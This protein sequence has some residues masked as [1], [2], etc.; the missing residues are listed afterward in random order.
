MAAER[1]LDA[2]AALFGE[3]GFAAVSVRDVALRAGVKKA[4]VFY[5][6]GSKAELFERVLDRYYEAHA[7]ALEA[8]ARGP[9]DAHE[10]LHR[11]LDGYLDFM[12]D[13]ERWVRLVQSELGAGSAH[14]PRIARGLE[15]LYERV[16]AVL[17]G[18]V[19]EQGPLAARHFFVSFAGIVNAYPTYAPALG[20]IFH[21]DPLAAHARR[22]RREHVHF[23]ADALLHALLERERGRGAGP[24]RSRG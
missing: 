3:R 14:L 11:L 8:V 18:L 16:R 2:A 22:E 23:V 21:G 15:L 13:S 4:S 9:G 5:Y 17:D 10:R 20:D 24:A 1:I 7:R 12:E 6:F 19:P